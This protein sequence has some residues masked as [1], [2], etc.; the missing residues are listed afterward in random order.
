M[1]R[2]LRRSV[3]AWPLPRR[4]SCVDFLTSLLHILNLHP[5][6]HAAAFGDGTRC[7][8]ASAMAPAVSSATS[9]LHPLDGHSLTHPHYTHTHT[10]TY[11]RTHT[12]TKIPLSG[13]PVRPMPCSL[14]GRRALP[15]A[16]RLPARPF[17]GRLAAGGS[18]HVPRRIPSFFHTQP[19]C[20]TAGRMSDRSAAV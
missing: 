3:T 14:H 6:P 9:S 8:P 16:T 18:A 4:P 11:T 7:G 19:P 5:T 17:A 1:Q 20:R 2:L 13:R 10:H 12:Y 15:S